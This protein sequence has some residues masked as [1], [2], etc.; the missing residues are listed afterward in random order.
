MVDLYHFLILWKPIHHIFI[1][2]LNFCS[3]LKSN[4]GPL[5]E[6]CAPSIGGTT[7][8]TP[9]LLTQIACFRHR[10]CNNPVPLGGGS[11]CRGNML[12][13]AE[14]ECYAGV[15]CSCKGPYLNDVRKIF[16]FFDPPRPFIRI[17]RNLSV[18][19][20]RKIGQ[21]LNPPSPPPCGRHLSIAPKTN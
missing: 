21:F 10:R 3:E 13:G 2:C 12:E 18:L 5:L 17:S 9:V 4:L 14:S 7:S 15:D 1:L 8:S 11:N 19:F 16:G 20:V 6:W